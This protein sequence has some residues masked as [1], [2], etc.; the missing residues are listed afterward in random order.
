MQLT[1]FQKVLWVLAGIAGLALVLA[2]MW[3]DYRSDQARTSEAPAFEAAFE[4]TDHN[5]VTRTEEDFAGRWMLVF[6]GFANCPDICPTRE[7]SA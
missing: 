5:G 1:S 7:S 6:F 2:L 3:M 4:L